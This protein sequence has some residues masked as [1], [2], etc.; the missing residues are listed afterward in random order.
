MHSKSRWDAGSLLYVMPNALGDA[1]VSLVAL[2]FLA[3]FRP[4]NSNLIVAS[5]GEFL[6]FLRVLDLPVDSWISSDDKSELELTISS[7]SEIVDCSGHVLAGHDLVKW[8]VNGSEFM[9]YSHSAFLEFG[10]NLGNFNLVKMQMCS[11]GFREVA[12]VQTAFID[13]YLGESEPAFYLELRLVHWFLFGEVMRECLIQPVELS[14]RFPPSYSNSSR[15]RYCICPAGSADEKK[16]PIINYITLIHE[17]TIE[18]CSVK[19]LLGPYERELVSVFQGCQVKVISPQSVLD[20]ALEIDNSDFIIANDCGPMHIAASLG[21]P[22]LAIFG[23][24]NPN[25]WF[26]YKGRAQGFIKAK[27]DDWRLVGVHTS[28]QVEWPTVNEVQ[29][30]I[31]SLLNGASSV[32]PKK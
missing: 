4:N 21:K 30:Q 6:S 1:I 20:L 27:T 14:W 32:E 19:V 13:P 26:Y 24:T 12:R 18:G 2:R 11:E 10:A 7:V 29:T 23:P 25:V 3:T 16:W 17:L 15:K 22:L 28:I 31:K 5:K 8:V 9:L